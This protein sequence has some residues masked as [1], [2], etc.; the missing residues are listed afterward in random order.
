MLQFFVNQRAM[1]FFL[2]KKINYFRALK[3]IFGFF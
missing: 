2:L 1:S 3:Q